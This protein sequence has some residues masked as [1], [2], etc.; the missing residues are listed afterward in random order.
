MTR[1]MNPEAR[2][3]TPT[4]DPSTQTAIPDA[5]NVADHATDATGDDQGPQNHPHDQGQEAEIGIVIGTE[6]TDVEDHAKTK[7]QDED[8]V[9]KT[10][11]KMTNGSQ[12]VAR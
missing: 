10:T 12:N 6:N 4:V 8:H 7:V 3:E 1:T 11:K 9:T 2:T 5:E